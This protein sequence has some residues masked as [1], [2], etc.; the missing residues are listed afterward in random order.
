MDAVTPSPWRRRL[1]NALI[2]LV[3]LALAFIAFGYFAVPL[4]VKSKLESSLQEELGRQATI[5]KIEFDPFRLKATIRDFVLADRVPGKPLLAFDQLDLDV[6]SASIYRRAPVLDA[7]RV[8]RPRVALTRNADGGYNIQDVIER[9]AAAPPGPPPRFSVNNIEIDDGAITFDDKPHKRVHEVT[10]IGIGIPFLSSL[11]YAAEIRVTPKL[12]AVVN[13][14]AFA[15]GGSASSPFV[16]VKEASLDVNLDALPLARY[17]EYV[18]L[19]LAAK[20]KD[21]ALTTRLK[22]AFVTDKG[23]PK[24]LK[25][26]G[27]A[28]VDRFALTRND[29]TPL[30]AAAKIDA[31]IGEADALARTVAIERIAVDAP[32]V[33]LRRLSDGALEFVRL[34]TPAAPAPAAAP[35]ATRA[36]SATAAAPAPAQAWTLRVA[37]ARISNGTLALSDASIDPAFAATLTGVA[38]TATGLSTADAPPARIEL[39]FDSDGARFDGKGE[40]DVRRLAGRGNFALSKFSLARLYPYYAAALALDVKRGSLALAGDFDVVAGATPLQVKLTGGSATLTDIELAVSDEKEPLWRIPS[41]AL[42]GIDFD[43]AQHR[44]TIDS[45]DGPRAAMR[46]VREADGTINF[47]R[48][49]RTTAQTGAGAPAAGSADATWAYAVRRITLERATAD[50]EDRGVV[51]PVKQRLTDVRAVGQN[52]SNA[53][54]AKGALDF[55]ARVGNS[56]RVALVGSLATNPFAGDWRVDAA[57]VDLMPFRVYVESRTNIV[58]TG[59]ALATKGRL[60]LDTAAAGGTRTTYAGDVTISDFGA[61]DRPTNQELVRWKTL[62]LTAVDTASAPPRLALGAVSLDDFYARIIVNADA[63]LNLQLLMASPD[64]AAATPAP[65]T[66]APSAASAAKPPAP[67]RTRAAAT[68]PAPSTGSARAAARL[69]EAAAPLSGDA[70]LPVSIGRIEVARGNVRFSDFFVK[71]NYTVN[72]T[73]VAGSVSAMSAAQAGDVALD[74]KVEHDAP[75]EVRGKVNPFARELSLDLT[76]KARDVD[77]PPLTPYA[78]KY[79]GYGIEKGKL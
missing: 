26:S 53:R 73:D 74:A 50:V 15:L 69:A 56:G 28:R 38:L 29:G 23:V 21:G 12:A 76:G 68:A 71:P 61:L 11:P 58:F 30:A 10:G 48:L 41:L 13:G 7:V 60:V 6:S 64:A 17:V 20:V 14:S 67:S 3:V 77:L 27:T 31:T 52:F 75:V 51:P 66:P 39:A 54:G 72:L 22:I 4:I 42:A 1:R 78:A 18:T 47:A 55:R 2:A 35:A 49:V 70:N 62:T 59:G 43:L 25:V 34:V 63:T 19:P 65:P 45:V 57:G 46:V 33:D 37:D 79:A 24:T 44:V 16:D 9:I 32:N 40:L 5:G 8:V 36:P